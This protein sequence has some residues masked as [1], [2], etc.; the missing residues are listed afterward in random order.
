MLILTSVDAQVSRCNAQSVVTKAAYLLFYR[1]RSDNPLGPPDVQKMVHQYMNGD[2]GSDSGS[3]GSNSPSGNS[4]NGARPTDDLSH[5]GSSGALIG[6]VA[7]RPPLHGGAGLDGVDDSG[8]QRITRYGSN[9]RRKRMGRNDGDDDQEL[10]PYDDDEGVS[11]EHDQFFDLG[12]LTVPPSGWGWS[13]LDRIRQNSDIDA[14]A[15][16]DDTGSMDANH[17]DH[18]DGRAIYRPLVGA[19]NAGQGSFALHGEN[20]TVVDDDEDYD[21]TLGASNTDKVRQS[22]EVDDEYG[23][24]RHDHDEDIEMKH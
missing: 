14:D 2:E 12:S 23:V 20:T 17:S 8:V 19:D 21:M 4:G 18:D 9:S 15:D 22:V 7:V 11:M 6:P 3:E 13:A 24:R 16:N 5:N 10:P 1:R